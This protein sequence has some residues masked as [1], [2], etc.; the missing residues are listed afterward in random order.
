MK[1]LMLDGEEGAE[2]EANAGPEQ[3]SESKTQPDLGLRLNGG[4]RDGG[5]DTRYRYTISSGIITNPGRWRGSLRSTGYK[6]RQH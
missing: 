2:S 5:N 4:W 3:N 6:C 1:Y